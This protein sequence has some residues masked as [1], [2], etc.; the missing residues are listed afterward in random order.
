MN[1]IN[2]AKIYGYPLPFMLIT[3]IIFILEITAK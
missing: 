3:A 1:L 2:K